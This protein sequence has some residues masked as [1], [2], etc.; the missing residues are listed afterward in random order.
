MTG[1][2]TRLLA[3]RSG[4]FTGRVWPGRRP[5]VDRPGGSGVRRAATR[6]LNTAYWTARLMPND[7][8][9]RGFQRRAR[10]GVQERQRDEHAHGDREHPQADRQPPSALVEVTLAE[11]EPDGRAAQHAEP[12]RQQDVGPD[13]DDRERRPPHVPGLAD[14]H[15]DQDERQQQRPPRGHPAAGELPRDHPDDE[16]GRRRGTRRRPWPEACSP[17]APRSSARGPVRVEIAAPPRGGSAGPGG[18]APGV[19][20]DG[21]RAAQVR[22]PVDPAARRPRLLGGGRARRARPARRRARPPPR[23]RARRGPRGQRPPRRPGVAHR[24]MFPCLRA[25][26]AS[27]LVAS[28]RSARAT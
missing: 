19:R 24:G 26:P 9:E 17:R 15:D 16:R 8:G 21:Q 13:H 22:G 4:P 10:A 27:R 5:A 18:R 23:R 20:A 25:G 2:Q 6:A 7:S 1:S 12:G 14:P 3:I 28:V 11:G